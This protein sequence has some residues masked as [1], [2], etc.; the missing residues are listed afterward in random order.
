MPDTATTV[1]E[2]LITDVYASFGFAAYQAQLLEMSLGTFLVAH[3]RVSDI[4]LPVEDL[5]GT[6]A[7]VHLLIASIMWGFHIAPAIVL[8]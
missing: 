8:K 6:E 4:N 1:S 5:L 7:S 2:K 3:Q